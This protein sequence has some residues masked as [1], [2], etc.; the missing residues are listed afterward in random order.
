MFLKNAGVA[1]ISDSAARAVARDREKVKTIAKLTARFF[2]RVCLFSGF[3]QS[4]KAF[5]YCLRIVLADF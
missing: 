3:L 1:T 2:R 4:D 5:K